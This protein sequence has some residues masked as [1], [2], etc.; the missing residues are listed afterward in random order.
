MIS[1][2]QNLLY[3]VALDTMIIQIDRAKPTPSLSLQQVLNTST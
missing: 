1:G 2:N 3:V